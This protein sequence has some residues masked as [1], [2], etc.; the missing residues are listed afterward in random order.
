MLCFPRPVD[1]L[2]GRS[3]VSGGLTSLISD[4]LILVSGFGNGR[5]TP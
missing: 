2:E 5:A 1:E 3:F 4:A